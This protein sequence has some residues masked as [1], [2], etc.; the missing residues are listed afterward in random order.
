[1]AIWKRPEVWI[2]LLI[3]LGALAYILFT[4]ANKKPDFEAPLSSDSEEKNLVVNHLKLSRDYGNARLD[5]SITL[6]NT[7]T[8][9]ITFLAP[10]TQLLRPDKSAVDPFILAFAQPE[11]L[12]PGKSDDRTLS[13]WLEE[14]DLANS[15]ILKIEDQTVTIKSSAPF[16]LTTIE[17]QS[18]THFTSENWSA[19]NDTAE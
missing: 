14:K 13:Y 6:K 18:T 3:T 8:K 10:D 2:L 7:T 12:P 5:L 11:H 16:D 4:Q 9:P 19:T 15:L 1:M 17:N